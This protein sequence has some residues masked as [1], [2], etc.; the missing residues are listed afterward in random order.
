VA[1]LCRHGNEYSNYTKGGQLT[2][3]VSDY[4]LFKKDSA[5]WDLHRVHAVTGTRMERK[6]DA[7]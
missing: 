4:Q 1:D 2:D 3:E 5:S 6:C 7:Y